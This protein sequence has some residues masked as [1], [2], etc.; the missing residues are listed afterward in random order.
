VQT[1]L[2]ARAYVDILEVAVLVDGPQATGTRRYTWQADRFASG[3]YLVR[4]DA[5]GQVRTRA[6]TL[7]R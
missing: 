5:G 4:L 1:G 6:L 3:L 7:V 2:P